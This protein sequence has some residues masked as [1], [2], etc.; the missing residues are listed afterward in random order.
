MANKIQPHSGL[1]FCQ[2][3]A[4]EQA[5]AYQKLFQKKYPGERVSALN[6]VYFSYLRDH[7]AD[8]PRPLEVPAW[9]AQVAM[10]NAYEHGGGRQDAPRERV[11]EAP[12]AQ[13]EAHEPGREPKDGEAGDSS[14]YYTETE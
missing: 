11:E 13:E 5:R 8:F 7:G 12:P 6:P 4:A 14:S 10:Q 9:F 2:P 1:N 3:G